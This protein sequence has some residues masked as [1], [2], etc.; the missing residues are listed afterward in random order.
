MSHFLGLAIFIVIAAGFVLHAGME[1]PWF[2]EWVGKL[3][4]DILIKKQGMTFYA[5]VTSSVLISAV[6]SFVLSLFSGKRN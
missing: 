4:G 5:P 2:I 6:L 3:P 1:L